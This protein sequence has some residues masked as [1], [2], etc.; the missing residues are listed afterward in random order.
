[1]LEQADDDVLRLLP[2]STKTALLAAARR[3]LPGVELADGVLPDA[4]TASLAAECDRVVL[5]LTDEC[6]EALDLSGMPCTDAACAALAPRCA[7]VRALDV[8]RCPLI[9]GA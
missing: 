4:A 3:R 2:L 1:V 9:T 8:R 6:G 7:R 5:S